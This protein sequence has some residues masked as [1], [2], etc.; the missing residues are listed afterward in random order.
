MAPPLSIIIPTYQRE[1]LLVDTLESLQPLLREGDEI[2]VI[3]QTPQHEPATDAALA[4]MARRG[5]IRYLR[6]KRPSQNE[7]MNIGAHLARNDILV[8]L[9]D[10]IVPA[11][12]F[13]EAHRAALSA[14]DAPPATCGQVLQ[15]W[16][17][18]P[19]EEVSDFDLGFNCAYA[20]AC[21]IRS[22]IG[23][24]FAIRRDV[25][26]A[27]GGMDENFN[28]ANYRNDAELAFRVCAHSGRRIRFLPEAGVRH[29]YAAGGNRAFGHKDTWG[30][31]GGSIGDYYFALKWL[32]P[33]QVA[34]HSLTRLV[35]ASLNRHTIARPW[36]VVSLALREC[37]AFFIAA[38]RLVLSP[39]KRLR[40]LD[41][42]EM[43]TV[44]PAA[45]GA[46]T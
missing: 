27:A 34:R 4:D 46:Q 22:L 3:D 9:D 30:H 42:Y 12:G 37:V 15:P 23:A 26:F 25:Y 41:E 18:A 5:L 1:R 39:H 35:R 24:N 13:L 8:F 10:D 2:I 16:N 14:P 7:A 44:A 40:K 20:H 17:P 11:A 32:P 19:V 29:L 28:G 36:L 33:A 21:D 43:D 31:I 38:K 6:R 45:P